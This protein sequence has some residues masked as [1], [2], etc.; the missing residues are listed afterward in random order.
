MGKE[1]RYWAHALTGPE[2]PRRE[3]AT[4][5]SQAGVRGTSA[6]LVRD[7]DLGLGLESALHDGPSRKEERRRNCS[8]GGGGKTEGRS[9]LHGNHLPPITCGA[10][11]IPCISSQCGNSAK[12]MILPHVT[13]KA[14]EA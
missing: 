7:A 1:D 2:R 14:A 9:T 4:Q 10:A 6:E 13:E 5:A 11:P 3:G 12:C 8:P